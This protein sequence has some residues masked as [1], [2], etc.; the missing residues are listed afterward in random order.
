MYSFF[1]KL[2]VLLR[3]LVVAGEEFIEDAMLNG[4]FK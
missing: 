3:C 4:I 1:E 2:V